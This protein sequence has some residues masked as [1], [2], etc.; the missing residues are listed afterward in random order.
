MDKKLLM[1]LLILAAI[2]IVIVGLILLVLAS[3]FIFAFLAG[4][5]YMGGSNHIPSQCTLTPGFTCVSYKLHANT[6]ELDLII[7]QGTGHTINVTGISCTQDASSDYMNENS[8]NNYAYNPLSI[9]SGEQKYVSQSGTSHMI[10]CTDAN[11][12]L[13]ADLK[14]GSFYSGR[15]YINYTELDTN[16]SKITTGAFS[17]KYE[18]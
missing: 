2:V 10:K 14:L 13:P 4:V 6:G 15:L 17:T 18:S 5:F 11:G 16:S 8:I 9:H 7:G 1:V 12:D 3:P